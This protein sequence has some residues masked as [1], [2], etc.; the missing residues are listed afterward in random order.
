MKKFIILA[1]AALMLAGCGA[2]PEV[3]GAIV[4]LTQE[5]V[6]HTPANVEKPMKKG[7]ACALNILGLVSTGDS[8][9]E[10]AQRNG[11]ITKVVSVDKDISG[12]NL[13]IIL[14]KSC[15]VVRGY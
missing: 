11:D 2:S 10:A 14:A 5:G 13:Y 8:T 4:V 6:N 1:I 12:I 3:G 9:I 7:E 15:T